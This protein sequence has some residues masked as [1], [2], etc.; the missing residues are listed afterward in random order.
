MPGR[1]ERRESRVPTNVYEGLQA[2]T[3]WA[4]SHSQ[5]F[6]QGDARRLRWQ[7]WIPLFGPG[8]AGLRGYWGRQGMN[9]HINQALPA[10]Q[11]SGTLLANLRR[12]GGGEHL[13]P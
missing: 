13:A 8:R 12:C 10:R 5:V 4:I 11:R 3:T 7:G 9:K 2:A 6:Y 1:V